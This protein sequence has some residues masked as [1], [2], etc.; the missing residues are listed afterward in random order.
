[1]KAPEIA[2]DNAEGQT[3]IS[4]DIESINLLQN[5]LKENK[6]K[7]ITLNV[8]APF[9]CSLMSPAAIKMKDKINSINFK[10]PIFDLIRKR[11]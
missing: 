3:I 6:K 8:S 2:N 1:M 10:K 9:H 11:I 7:F 4:G 5:V